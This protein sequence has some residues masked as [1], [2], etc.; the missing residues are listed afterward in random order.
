MN[1]TDVLRFLDGQAEASRFLTLDNF[2]W[3]YSRAKLYVYVSPDDWVLAFQVCAYF[4]RT[5]EI[6]N[7]CYTYCPSLDGGRHVTTLRVIHTGGKDPE[8][9]DRH[10]FMLT[11]PSGPVTCEVTEKDYHA[12]K[13]PTS[14]LNPPL[15]DIV[16]L[17][18]WKYSNH[19]FL[20]TQEFDS[21]LIGMGLLGFSSLL[22]LDDWYHPNV[23][24]GELPS[25]SRSM[26]QIADVIAS[27]DASKYT[28]RGKGNTHLR[29]WSST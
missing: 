4:Q 8:L 1:P 20:G 11:F 19:V 12:Y 18:G 9:S 25:K 27:N 2:Y 7:F 10:R 6:G 14:S 22:E 28:L 24:L 29:K 17:V 3:Y 15:L 26:R 21:Y 16:R 23:A 13:I 5:Q